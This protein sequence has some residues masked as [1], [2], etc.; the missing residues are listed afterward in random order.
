MKRTIQDQVDDVDGVERAD[1]DEIGV[2]AVGY[3]GVSQVEV[4]YFFEATKLARVEH[5]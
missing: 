1:L 2:K 3:R 4:F 5:E